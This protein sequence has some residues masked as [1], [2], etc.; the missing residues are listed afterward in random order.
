MKTLLR[1]AVILALAT[2][3]TAPLGLTGASADSDS[4]EATERKHSK[5]HPV[6]QVGKM[7]ILPPF[8]F[9]VQGNVVGVVK[10]SRAILIRKHNKMI[11]II[12][13][14]DLPPGGAVTFWNCGWN[15]PELCANNSPG[16]MGHCGETLDDVFLLPDQWC[17][18]VDG[19]IVR[20][21]GN[22]FLFGLLPV[23]GPDPGSEDPFG[24]GP[25]LNAFGSEVDL[26]IRYHGPA[27][28]DPKLA[29]RQI[30]MHD[31][32]CT[33]ETSASGEGDPEFPP[34]DLFGCHELQ[35]VHFGPAGDKDDH[36]DNHHPSDS[37]K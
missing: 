37:R 19:G 2:A 22:I 10:R 14:R 31:G 3:F 30:T 29:R 33:A 17:L 27:N 1:F 35:L 5:P 9:A 28:R 25:I 24:L 7:G 26:I 34:D 15:S 21:N 13:T 23:G 20:R 16:D 12:G 18:L 11:Q 36:D 6:F 4:G 8:E 32:G